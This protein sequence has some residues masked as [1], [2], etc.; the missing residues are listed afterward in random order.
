[1]NKNYI[2]VVYNDINRPL[3]DYPSKLSSFLYKKYNLKKGDKLL[4]VGC[5][6][7]EFWDAV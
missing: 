2:D 1:M 5:G 4:E 3:T 6:R 7:G